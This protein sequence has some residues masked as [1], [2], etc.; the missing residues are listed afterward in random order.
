LGRGL[1]RRRVVVLL[2]PAAGAA[3][4]GGALVVGRALAVG[5][6]LVVD[7]GHVVLGR[8]VVSGPG[9]VAGRRLGGFRLRLV[10]GVAGHAG[11][12]EDELD[13]VGLLGPRAGLAAQRL[14]DRHQLVAVL[15]LEGG[16]LE[17]GGVHRC[18]YLG[19]GGVGR[20]A[21][22]DWGGA[23]AAVPLGAASTGCARMLPGRCPC[24][25]TLAPRRNR[26]DVSARPS[27]LRISAAG[28]IGAGGA[29]TR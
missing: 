23:G 29:A 10:R 9:R 1:I 15:A 24:G 4:L 17:G 22:E 13:D 16:A 14:G 18:G 27:Y 25:P 21:A 20:L 12:L 28:A 8:L 3:L 26:A 5:G 2:G 19:F 11:Q 7:L 6:A